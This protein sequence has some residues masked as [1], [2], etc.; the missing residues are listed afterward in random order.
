MSVTKVKCP[1]CQDEVVWGPESEFRPFCSD[2]CRLIDLGEWANE[3]KAIAG[4]PVYDFPDQA[5]NETY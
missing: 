5:D 2:R 4:A 1:T 3:E